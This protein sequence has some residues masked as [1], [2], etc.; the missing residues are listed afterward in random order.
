MK[1]IFIAVKVEVGDTMKRII[2]SYQKGL[3][4][5][6][7]KWTNPENIH[8]TLVFLGDTEQMLI[9]PI[10]S[11]L[12]EKCGRTGKFELMIRGAG[13]FRN[14]GDP[15]I[16]WMGI[17]PNEKLRQ[18]N[19]SIA[20]GLKQLKFNIEDRP[21]NPHLT[22]G[23]IKHLK[24]KDALKNLTEEYHNSEIQRVHINE[25]ILYESILLQSGPVYKPLA[26]I[27]L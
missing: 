4:H 12:E 27:N 10:S 9:E 1:R 15:R 25:V 11:M 8:V 16:I 20:D 23:R 24:D 14:L 18:L 13:V 22:I 26:V 3:V 7:I 19:G 5:E 6:S 21:Y 2:L 17:E